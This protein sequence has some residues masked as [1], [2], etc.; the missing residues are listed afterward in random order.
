M[1]KRELASLRAEKTIVLALLI[2]LFVAAFSSFL[3]VGLVSLYDPGSAAGYSVETAVAGDDAN[4]LLRAVESTDGMDGRL[5]PGR[6][7]AAEAFNDREVDAAML[8]TATTD[9]RLEVRV[10]VP[11]SN[12]ATT[13]VVVRAREAL[14]AFERL[15]RD[16]RSASLTAETLELPPGAGAS[17]YFGFTYTV[18]VPLL[19]F[20]PVFIAGSVTVDSLTEELERGTLELLRVAP[21]TMT[22]IV[23]GKLLA[24]AGLAPVQAALW[25]AL[26][27]ANGTAIAPGPNLV[28]TMAGVLALLGLTA[29][30]AALVTALGAALALTAPDRRAA[31]TVYSLGVLGLFGLAA[32]SPVNPAN[33]AAKLAVGSGDPVSYLAVGAVVVFGAVAVAAARVGVARYGP[34]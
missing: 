14:R 23:E 20:L 16:Q 31:Q 24:A 1:A 10:L 17:P 34:A 13:L 8:A 32:L 15:E 33:V 6:E 22:D 27:S 11:D 29:G 18:L 9:G 12:V 28:S 4:D 26:L 7:A 21:V 2:Q 25:L 3:V 30:L 19:L 5:Y